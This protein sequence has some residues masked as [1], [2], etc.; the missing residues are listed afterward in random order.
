MTLHQKEHGK[1]KRVEWGGKVT[2]AGQDA[3]SLCIRP[4]PYPEKAEGE[5][6]VGGLTPD[7][8]VAQGKNELFPLTRLNPVNHQ[9][10]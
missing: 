8:S 9:G 7:F 2:K 10:T 3:R 4:L 1:I 6:D 5:G